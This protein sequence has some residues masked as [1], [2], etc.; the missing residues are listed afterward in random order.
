MFEE[1]SAG[2]G[3]WEVCGGFHS[4]PATSHVLSAH[5]GEQGSGW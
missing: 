4:G 1:N 3:M 2:T 5:L